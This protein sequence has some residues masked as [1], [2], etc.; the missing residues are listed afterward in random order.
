MNKFDDTMLAI[1][2]LVCFI[3]YITIDG[4]ISFHISKS[5]WSCA[6]SEVI[7]NKPVCTNYMRNSHE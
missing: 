5:E 3:G 7:K 2:V 6:K 1:I 4:I